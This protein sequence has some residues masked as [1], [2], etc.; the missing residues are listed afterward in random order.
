ML[1][2]LCFQQ[3]F[4][5]NFA[6]PKAVFFLRLIFVFLLILRRFCILLNFFQ[7]QQANNLSVRLSPELFYLFFAHVKKIS[8]WK[9][10]ILIFFSPDL[11]SIF[12]LVSSWR[13]ISKLVKSLKDLVM[14]GKQ[15][16][17]L[18]FISLLPKFLCNNK[19]AIKR[20]YDT[21]KFEFFIF[22]HHI[23]YS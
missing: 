22:I 19:H 16:W 10:E 4:Y 11:N 23:I 20:T 21:I 1:L 13:K 3:L 5:R 12:L 2:A 7:R 14:N 6:W 8:I 15:R 18:L 9:L 17:L